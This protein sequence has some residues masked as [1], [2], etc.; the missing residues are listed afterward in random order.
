MHVVAI[1]RESGVVR[2]NLRDEVL[3]FGD[4]LLLYGPRRQQRALS[5]DPNL[6]LL[7]TPEGEAPRSRRAP[8]A[9]LVTGVALVPVMAGWLPVAVG[10][11]AGAVL[12]VLTRCLNPDEAYRAVDWPTLV[13]VAGMLALGAALGDTGAMEL[14]GGIL[15]G[16]AGSLGVY[17]V[18]GL[19]VVVTSVGGQIIP[20][21]AVVVLMAP[22]AIAGAELLGVSPHAFVMSV[23]IASTSLASPVAHPAHALVMAPAGYR[24]ADFL[25]LGVPMTLLVLA[26]TVLVTPIFFPF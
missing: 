18:L 19:L 21:S 14:L 17:A 13:L 16:G 23:A 26:L 22:V 7:Q 2:T 11:L 25:R 24:T 3:R 8:L 1:K 12:M 20:G 4:A 15:L 5:R 9:L 6:I 10:V